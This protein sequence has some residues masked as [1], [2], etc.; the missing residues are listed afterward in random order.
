L[1]SASGRQRTPR[2]LLHRLSRTERRTR[3]CSRR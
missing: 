2:R 1:S 3:S